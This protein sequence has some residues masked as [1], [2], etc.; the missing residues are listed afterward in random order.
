MANSG[1]LHWPPF[2]IKQE[3]R[4]CSLLFVC[5]SF[6][7]WQPYA[8]AVIIHRVNS[9]SGNLTAH[10]QPGLGS[11]LSRGLSGLLRRHS[12][13]DAPS[14]GSGAPGR[15]SPRL[16][17]RITF[18]PVL[19]SSSYLFISKHVSFVSLYPFS[20]LLQ[21]LRYDMLVF[22]ENICCWAIL[23]MRKSRPRQVK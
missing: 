17:F 10:T 1:P 16:A 9:V 22:F 2:S 4:R 6:I 13:T 5:L 19:L 3:V 15:P 21:H 11:L 23:Q 20:E 12:C 8:G 7:L 18:L 14:S